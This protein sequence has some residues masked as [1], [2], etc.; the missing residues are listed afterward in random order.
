[1]SNFCKYYKQKKQVS[2]NGGLTWDDVSPAE[3]QAGELYE[4]ESSDCQDILQNRWV[5]IPG[6]YLCE[7]KNMYEKEIGQYSVDG[8]ETWEYYYPSIFK[9]GRLLESN[10]D[11]CNNKWEGHYYQDGNYCASGYRWVEGRGCVA[12]SAGGGDGTGGSLFFKYRDPVKYVR[13]SSSTSTTLTKEDVAYNHYKLYEG[14]IGDCVTSIGNQAFLFNYSLSSIT[15]SSGVTSIGVEAFRGCS[16][17]TSI[18]IPS[19]VTTIGGYAFFDC[20][21]L[22]GVTIPNGVTSIDARTFENC[23][24][25]SSMTVPNSVT[26]IGLLAFSGCTSLTSCTLG[27][28]VTEI[29]I[30]YNGETIFTG[31]TSLSQL[32]IKSFTIGS[33]W[34]YQLGY[35]GAPV[36]ITFDYRVWRIEQA[37]FS[38]ANILKLNSAFDGVVNLDVGYIGKAAFRECSGIT[39]LI[40]SNSISVI[41]E[42]AFYACRELSSITVYRTT[43]P[44][45]GTGAFTYTNCPIYVPA[46]SV[47]TYKA[48]CGWIGYADRIQAIS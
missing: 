18:E 36:S 30:G 7:N 3:Y 40:I 33:G 39:S 2:Y 32:T 8:G 20:Y 29:A 10:S 48:A 37:A 13:C 25:I 27:T 23:T 9:L 5:A 26:S 6:S 47:D 24:S 38:K 43:P 44:T 42:E 34:F 31:C 46:G 14:V 41:E 28:G 45:L 22:T 19:G 21:N 11:I 15:I 1:M 4:A 12:V 35:D 17:L 16:T